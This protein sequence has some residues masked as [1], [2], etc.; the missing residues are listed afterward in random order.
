MGHPAFVTRWGS[1]RRVVVAAACLTS[2][3]VTLRGGDALAQSPVAS[4]PEKIQLTPSH[5]QG[6]GRGRIAVTP[7]AAAWQRLFKAG[8]ARVADFPLPD[9]Q[10]VD[11]EV[12]S[13]EIVD[14]RTHFL[15]GHDKGQGVREVAGPE[16]RFF[17]GR[18]AGDPDS[19]VTLN[20]FGGRIAGFVRH[21]GHEYTFGPRS[22]AIDRKGADDIEL[23]DAAVESG[24]RGACDGDQNVGDD[25]AFPLDP[26][27]GPNA[28]LSGESV[29]FAR[30][31]PVP[32]AS[33]DANTL[34]VGYIA[35]EGTVEWVTKLGGVAAATTYTLN[36]MSQVS[37]IYENDIKV[38][39]KVPYVLM[40]TV[41]PDGYS[42][43]SN[44]TATV[45]DEMR[46]KWNGTP[47]LQAVFRSAAHVFS[48]YPSG[49]AG[50]AYI[51]VLCGN[52]PVNAT[53][54]DYGVSLL[55]GNGASWERRL[56]AHE[57]GHNFSSPHS[58]CYAPELDQCNN[59]ETG[60]YAGAVVQT[61]GTIM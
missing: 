2:L 52:V 53:S 50:R 54:Y 41:E 51:N 20:L 15:V 45:L 38:Q 3:L 48:T 13:V 55:E 24:P 16:M 23:V 19:L 10:R 28:S 17:R 8:S 59:T 32:S 49:G 7:D 56:L 26:P 9:G 34:L 11:L 5:P 22:F 40:N 21:D 60:C 57:I 47:S 30:P 12:A 35:V 4:R 43:A 27:S 14:G 31:G 42:G 6:R 25:G 37:A 29:S 58:H 39:L 44:S 36:L 18:V 46:A 1:V 33:I 61:T